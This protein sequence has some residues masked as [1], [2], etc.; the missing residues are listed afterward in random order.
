MKHDNLSLENVSK[1][2][3]CGILNDLHTSHKMSAKTK[4]VSG[5]QLNGETALNKH[6]YK[7]LAFGQFRYEK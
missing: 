7:N 5:K 4:V 2:H 3:Y 6:P 1:Q